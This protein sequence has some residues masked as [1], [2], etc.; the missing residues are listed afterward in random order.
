MSQPQLIQGSWATIAEH[1]QELMDRDD[2]MLIVPGSRDVDSTQL[3]KEG[4]T[5]A[6]ALKGRTGLVSFEPSDLSEDTG[7]KFTDL[8]VLQR[9]SRRP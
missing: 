9:N 4:M 3:V 7:R 5:L 6:E 8:L 1:A 2:L